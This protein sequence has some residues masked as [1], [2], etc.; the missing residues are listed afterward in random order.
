MLS[1]QSVKKVTFYTFHEG[2]FLLYRGVLPQIIQ[3][4][5]SITA[6]Y[7][8]HQNVN[9]TFREYPKNVAK[10]Y[11]GLLLGTIDSLLMPFERVQVIL[12]DKGYNHTYKNTRHCFQQLVTQH[13]FKELYR[14]LGLVYFRNILGSII[15]ISLLLE[16]EKILRQ[17]QK[18]REPPVVMSAT[19]ILLDSLQG[20]IVSI[21]LHPLNVLRVYLHKQVGERHMHTHIAFQKV[22]RENGLYFFWSGLYV[23]LIRSWTSW[24]LIASSNELY[25]QIYAHYR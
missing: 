4:C 7:I 14:G 10:I 19:R 16:K 2:V 24:V 22:Y 11:S 25:K 8:V 1:G 20:T 21:I 17:E 5:T 12:A 13:G 3:R 6:T 15:F 9:M 18:M 23:N